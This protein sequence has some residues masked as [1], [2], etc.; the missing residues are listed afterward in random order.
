MNDLNVIQSYQKNYNL[1]GCL[2]LP[3]SY[4]IDVY[5]VPQYIIGVPIDC[6]DK[7]FIKYSIT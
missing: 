3:V 2:V 7:S 5:D 1:E 4:N 6:G